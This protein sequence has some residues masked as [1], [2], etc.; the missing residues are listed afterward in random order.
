MK[1]KYNCNEIKIGMGGYKTYKELD[2]WIK[3]RNLVKEVYQVTLGLP[4]EEIYGLVSQMRR[5]AVSIP[6]NC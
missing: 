3:S 2:V 4:K 1:S 5:S 6:S